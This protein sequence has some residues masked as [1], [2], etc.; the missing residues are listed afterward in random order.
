MMLTSGTMPPSGVN[1]SCMPFTAPQLASV[2]VVAKSAV[3]AIPKRTSFA[4]HVAAG[5]RRAGVL[6]DAV[7]Q[8]IAASL[9]RISDRDARQ[10]QNRHRGP[11]GPAVALRA[12][13]SAERV[14]EARAE[15]E[16]HHDLHEIGQRRRI[17]ER[18]RAIG[19]ERAAAVRAENLDGFLRSERSLRDHL[20]GNRLR[21]RLAVG[22]GRLDRLRIQQ[23]RRVVRPQILNHALRDENQ[24]RSQDMPAAGPTA[25]SA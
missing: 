4:L 11:D 2:V 18:M 6:V 13:H 15:R 17:F 3:E 14:R 5:L 23:L 9:R 7:Q 24:A 21:R 20:V 19:V 16:H 22:A 8:R 12:R 25:C 10:A 1:E